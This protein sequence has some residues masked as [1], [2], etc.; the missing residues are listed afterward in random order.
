MTKSTAAAVLITALLTSLC[1]YVG[2]SLGSARDS[3]WLISAVKVPGRMALD[4]IADDMKKHRYAEACHRIEVLRREWKA[5]DQE[6]GFDGNAIGNI[7]VKFSQLE[8]EAAEKV[9]TKRP[10]QE[11]PNKP[12]PQ[13]GSP[14][15]GPSP[16]KL[17]D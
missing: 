5:F 2:T 4:T 15:G 8:I 12:Q 14:L 16:G 6:S 13:S 1:W 3:V 17:I 10:V 11:L 9:S 7:M